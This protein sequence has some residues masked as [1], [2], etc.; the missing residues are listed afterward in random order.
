MN[1]AT[2]RVLKMMAQNTQ[3]AVDAARAK[4]ANL[5]PKAPPLPARPTITVSAMRVPMGMGRGRRG[6]NTRG[7]QLQLV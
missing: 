1:D 3:A 6:S 7:H 2:K 4:P 5:A